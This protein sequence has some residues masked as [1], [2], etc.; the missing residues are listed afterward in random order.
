MGKFFRADVENV[1][2]GTE[3]K[4]RAQNNAS[5]ADATYYGDSET[6]TVTEAGEHDF[7]TWSTDQRVPTITSCNSSGYEI[8]QF[9][10]GE[11]VSV[12]GTG[13]NA[14]TNYTIW[15][16]LDP[17]IENDAINSS[18]DPSTTS[19]KNETVTTDEG[20]NFSAELIWSIPPGAEVTNTAYDIVVDNLENGT[21]DTYNA[22]HDGL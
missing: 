15:I 5:I 19:P 11:N 13:L 3:I 20:G 7:G 10:P 1:S 22:A 9:A 14:S 4:C 8:N 17:V 18:E 21:V 2:V 6:L 12:K 16:Q